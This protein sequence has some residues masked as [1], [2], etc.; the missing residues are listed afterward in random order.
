[1]YR[2]KKMRVEFSSTAE[3]AAAKGYLPNQCLSGRRSPCASG[4]KQRQ[5]IKNFFFNFLPA[6]VQTHS[7]RHEEVQ[8]IP[9]SRACKEEGELPAKSTRAEF[10]EDNERASGSASGYR[11]SV[12]NCRQMISNS[13]DQQSLRQRRQRHAD[14]DNRHRSGRLGS[15]LSN[16]YIRS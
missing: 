10:P 8:Q 14:G 13:C 2:R 16:S 4:K 7:K 9:Y 11:G 15:R 1:V 3:E 5:T 6:N 12:C